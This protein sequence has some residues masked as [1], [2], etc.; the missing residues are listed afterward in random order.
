MCCQL[1]VDVSCAAGKVL[2]SC[3]DLTLDV[4]LLPLN[5]QQSPSFIDPLHDQSALIEILL[6][7]IPGDLHM[8]HIVL[9]TE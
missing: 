7:L 8:L 5:L 1:F 4:E 9:G 3:Q 2:S 6:D